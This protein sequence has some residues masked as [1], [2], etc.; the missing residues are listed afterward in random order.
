MRRQVRETGEETGGET[1]VHSRLPSIHISLQ[2]I[3][4]ARHMSKCPS[5]LGPMTALL[6]RMNWEKVEVA[7]SVI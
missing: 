3:Q 2:C 6:Q 5:Y 1:Y 4:P 7:A